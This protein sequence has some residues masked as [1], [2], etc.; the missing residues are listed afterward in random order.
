MAFGITA[1]T[2]KG[3]N[4]IGA[5]GAFPAF[6]LRRLRQLRETIAHLLT[7]LKFKMQYRS[8]LPM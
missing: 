3:P 8:F 6:T 5:I 7:V 4:V 1:E 2:D